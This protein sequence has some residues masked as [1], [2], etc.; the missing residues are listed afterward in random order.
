MLKVRTSVVNGTF[1]R[2]HASAEW[3]PGVRFV[4]L[5]DHPQVLTVSPLVAAGQPLCSQ[6]F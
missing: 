3:G 5:L 1:D 2:D 4:G 6:E